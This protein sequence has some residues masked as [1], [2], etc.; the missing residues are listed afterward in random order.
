MAFHHV[1]ELTE[2]KLLPGFVAK[3]IH[4]ERMTLGFW[5]IQAGNQLP[6]H[7]HPHEQISYLVDGQFEFMLGDETRLLEAGSVVVIPPNVA[8]SGRA[9]TDCQVIDLFSPVRE[10]YR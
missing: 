2:R 10:D 5:T 4:A 6:R 7:A 3:F 9:L 8:H 1:A